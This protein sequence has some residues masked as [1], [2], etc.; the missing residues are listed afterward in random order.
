MKKILIHFIFIITNLNAYSS[1]SAH[2]QYKSQY[3]GLSV[4][5]TFGELE[6]GNEE[7][8]L[9][10]EFEIQHR[11]LLEKIGQR[12]RRNIEQ[13]FQ[14]SKLTYLKYD[15]GKRRVFEVFVNRFGIR[16]MYFSYS[17]NDSIT[18][19]KE[20]AL[21]KLLQ[22][23]VQETDFYSS[24]EKRILNHSNWY[25]Q[26]ETFP[27]SLNLKSG[28]YMVTFN[29]NFSC[30]FIPTTEEENDIFDEN[31]ESKNT[32]INGFWNLWN[33]KVFKIYF[34]SQEIVPFIK[35]N[36][37]IGVQRAEWHIKTTNPSYFELRIIK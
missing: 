16:K 1:S 2:A 5:E 6:D 7:A 10:Q 35:S 13:Y 37:E 28:K 12:L 11:V 21:R 33:D 31:Y 29:K 20:M 25:L 3:F 18:S 34:S 17:S 8:R 4:S 30:T 24:F 19:E 9:V 23:F 27:Y 36:S 15:S 14:E 26:N 32:S 22:S